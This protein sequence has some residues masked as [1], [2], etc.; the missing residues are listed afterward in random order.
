LDQ[1]IRIG[2]ADT[3]PHT[4]G[5]GN[6]LDGSK[7]GMV[8]NFNFANWG[9]TC[10]KKRESCIR[11]IAV[12]EFG[13]ALGFDHEQNHKDHPESCPSDPWGELGDIMITR[14][15]MH[16][17]MNYCNPKWSGD[18]K[19]S[20]KDIEG[21]QAWYGTPNQPATRYDGT[22]KGKLTY[23]DSGCKADPV[24]LIIHGSQV[25]GML[26]A[27]DGQSVKT[28][29]TLDEDS[30]SLDQLE[31]RVTYPAR[32]NYVDIIS[33]S[34]TLTEGTLHSSDCGDGQYSFRRQ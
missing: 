16:S 23:C 30:R 27:A 21:L 26:R 12:H 8:L 19:L 5:L 17:V 25:E 6:Q 10:S 4:K 28:S 3:T 34:G 15:D 9:T 1:G 14:Y 32:N 33:L 7:E 24:T 13:H 20:D 11:I 18:G 29:A 22:W 31:F 2:I